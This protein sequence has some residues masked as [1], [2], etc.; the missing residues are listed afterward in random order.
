MKNECQMCGG[1]LVLL[2]ALGAVNWYRCRNCG[3]QFSRRI[4]MK[5]LKAKHAGYM[6]IIAL[7]FLC[8]FSGYAQDADVQEPK[9]LT[10]L[11]AKK[12]AMVKKA[13]APIM[14]DYASALNDMKKQLGAKGDAAG[15]M[16]VQKELDGLKDSMAAG[17][18]LSKEDDAEKMLL[19]VWVCTG[20]SGKGH[21]LNFNE[22][23]SF[24][25]NCGVPGSWS[26]KDGLLEI[27]FNNGSYL[28]AKVPLKKKMPWATR[29]GEKWIFEKQK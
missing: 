5:T 12:D 24:G 3:M 17:A 18:P 7:L 8:A 29:D 20:G 2:G 23:H 25:C 22:D 14:K 28:S 27:K 21:I 4:P 11:R 26:I 13:I 15:M 6:S 16:A 10:A 9:E 1:S 19:G